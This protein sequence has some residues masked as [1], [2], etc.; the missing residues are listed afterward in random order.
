MWRSSALKLGR[1][2]T[3]GVM[4]ALL[5]LAAACGEAPKAT[6]PSP[7]AD[8]SAAGSV[9][10]GE[11]AVPQEALPVRHGVESPFKFER[12]SRE[13]G[14]SQ[15]TVSCILQ[16]SLGFMW[17]C[18]ADGLNRYDGYGFSVY[19]HDPED[20]GSLGP[21]EIWS[22]YEDQEGMLWIWKYLGTLDRYDRNTD[23]FARYDL[24]DAQDPEAAASDLI[25]TLYEDPGGT[26][27]V[28]TYRSGLQWY[29]RE[30]DRFVQY[31]HDPNDPSSLSNDRVYTIYE[32][33]DGVLWVGTLEGLNRLDRETGRFTR[34]RHDPNDPAS[35]GSD[36]VQHVFE[37]RAG[38][39]WVATLG[40]GLEQFDR[41]MGRVVARYQ[42]DPDDPT[43]IDETSRISEIYED[44]TGA[45]WLV[46]F[47][48]RLDKLDPETRKRAPSLATATLLILPAGCAT[49]V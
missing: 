11:G 39:F 32:D 47:D 35:L 37:D 34:Y 42:H 3:L 13:E 45:L 15:G 48:R 49:V 36:I 26:L 31:R 6:L 2:L 16:D 10:N 23:S 29:D 22:V 21:G 27:W 28:G 14:L 44:R 33:G 17:F 40:V 4:L 19:R 43:T 30:K 12:I 18:T 8:L 25:W 46:H 9:A 38:R 41:Q 1:I 24:F 7:E 5:L 20:P